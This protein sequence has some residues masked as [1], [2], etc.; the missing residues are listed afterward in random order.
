MEDEA[1]AG[2]REQGE[3]DG[4]LGE[5]IPLEHAGSIA[6][7]LEHAGVERQYVLGGGLGGRRRRETRDRLHEVGQVLCLYRPD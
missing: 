2:T 6:V 1:P 3:D 7:E 5:D 4:M